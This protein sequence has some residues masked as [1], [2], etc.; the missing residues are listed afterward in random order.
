MA[1]VAEAGDCESSISS[2]MISSGSPGCHF[3][4]LRI[5]NAHH[6]IGVLANCQSVA[7]LGPA[8]RIVL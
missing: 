1:Q 7:L 8:P 3:F 6:P 2:V 4:G 5:Y